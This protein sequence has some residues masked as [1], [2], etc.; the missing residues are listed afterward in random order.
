MVQER[1]KADPSPESYRNYLRV[2]LASLH[3][4]PKFRVDRSAIIQDTLLKAVRDWDKLRHNGPGA[5][6]R[7]MRQVLMHTMIDALRAQDA[8]IEPRIRQSLE[9]SSMR[10]S[11][12]LPGR[13][14]PPSMALQQEERAVRV[15]NALAELCERQRQAVILRYWYD[16][17]LAQI[18]AEL[19]TTA[20]AVAGL[21]RRAIR[22][23]G[24]LL[25]EEEES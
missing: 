15:A 24:G 20:P 25:R 19:Q 17:S 18:A 5:R 13:E 10:L 7:W 21:L 8:G 11:Q 2:V 14:H 22:Q 23:L 9:E 1:M 3:I 4:D 6:V 12:I 16:R